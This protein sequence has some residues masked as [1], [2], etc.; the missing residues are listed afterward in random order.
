MALPNE[1][2]RPLDRPCEQQVSF[3]L[4]DALAD[5]L[6]T[7]LNRDQVIEWDDQQSSLHASIHATLEGRQVV[8][9]EQ[10]LGNRSELNAALV[11][12]ATLDR[13]TGYDRLER[14]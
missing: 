7:L 6:D 11:D 8:G 14:V 4:G 2:R 3:F 5:V 10:V 12:V 9:C 13:L 1:S